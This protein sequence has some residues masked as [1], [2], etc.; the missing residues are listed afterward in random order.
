MGIGSPRLLKRLVLRTAAATFVGLVFAPSAFAD[1]I[2]IGSAL[3]TV[4]GTVQ[5]AAPLPQSATQAPATALPAAPSVATP[6][7]AR[8]A[9]PV[10]P[11]QATAETTGVATTSAAA[12]SA[13][14]QSRPSPSVRRPARPHHRGKA[15]QQ[16][17]G[18]S[19]SPRTSLSPGEALVA[20]I[21]DFPSRP[22]STSAPAPPRPQAPSPPRWPSPF[23]LGLGGTGSGP[24]GVGLGLLLLALAAE[25]GVLGAPGLGRKVSLLLATPRSYPFL[26]RLERP[27]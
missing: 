12:P 2:G 22:R 8:T 15:S 9:A 6:V 5:G 16:L 25:L 18:A 19:P 14:T 26:L 23:S 17:G 27:D 1:D 21:A 3:A 4:G 11:L 20:R 10:A 13:R 7:V 24:A